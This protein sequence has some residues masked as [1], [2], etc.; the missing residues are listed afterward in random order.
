MILL[1]ISDGPDK[2]EKRLFEQDYIIVGRSRQCDVVLSDKAIS[3]Q[4]IQISLLTDA[5]LTS[6]EAAIM[7]LPQVIGAGVAGLFF[8]Y[9]A[10]RLT[11]RWLIPM[12]LV[13]LA[14]SLLIAANLSPG[15][16]VVV[17]A[18]TLGAAGGAMR[19]IASHRL[20]RRDAPQPPPSFPQPVNGNWFLHPAH[21]SA[22]RSHRPPSTTSRAPHRG[23]H[24]RNNG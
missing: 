21:S 15:L 6:T 18:I 16:A 19:S 20:R 8:G 23:D 14:A 10:D 22:P 3:R 4:H 12:P 2:G 13:L 24:E 5:G 11:G 9:L 1:E 7:F 17:Y